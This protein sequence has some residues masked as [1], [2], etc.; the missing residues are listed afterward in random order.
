[1][2]NSDSGLSEAQFFVIS[3]LPFEDQ[4]WYYQIVLVAGGIALWIGAYTLIMDVMGWTAMASVDNAEAIQARRWAAT[5]A[6]ATMTAYF[7]L[8][9][10]RGFGG[11]LLSMFW[12]P[13]LIIVLMPDQAF[14][15]FGPTPEHPVT[16]G[17]VT[18]NFSRF[19]ADYI[20]IIA[21]GHGGTFFVIF[22]IGS[23]VIE[24]L[25][26]DTAKANFYRKWPNPTLLYIAAQKDTDEFD[27]EGPKTQAVFR[28]AGWR[29]ADDYTGLTETEELGQSERQDAPKDQSLEDSTLG[30]LWPVALLFVGMAALESVVYAILV[31]LTAG[32][33][34]AI[35]MWGEADETEAGG[36]TSKE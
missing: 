31:V 12:Y 30:E 35:I 29:P 34:W 23:A 5:G 8:G 13:L 24:K 28:E 33:V 1:M 9:M 18:E 20:P 14:G 11:P 25:G 6:T 7:M 16:T 10:F 2:P 36:E 19:F 15:L 22:V 17:S 3:L 27:A 32:L 21:L 4:Q 26:G